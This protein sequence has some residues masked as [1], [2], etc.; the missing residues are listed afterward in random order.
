MFI[1]LKRALNPIPNGVLENPDTMWGGAGNLTPH[2]SK[3]MFDVEI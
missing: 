3:S 2:P 1:L